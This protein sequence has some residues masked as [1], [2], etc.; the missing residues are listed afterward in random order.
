MSFFTLMSVAVVLAMDAFAVSV[1]A[2]V[3]VEKITHRHFF[4]LAFHFGLFQAAMFSLG[5]SFGTAVHSMVAAVDHWI[6]FAL[7]FLVGANIIKGSSQKEQ[8]QS[9]TAADPTAGWQ[10]VTLSFATSI[11]ALAVGFSLAMTTTSVT[12]AAL[13]IG[14][15]AAAFTLTGMV[16]GRRIGQMWGRRAEVM[17]GVVL[18]VI[19]LRIVW[20]H[21]A[22]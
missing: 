15:T 11:D 18:M 1:V 22:R 9:Q 7:L 19:G 20:E 16:L 2:G 17:G 21:M 4:R 3:S 6:A 12:I 13:A 14:L 5:W 10:L 8:E